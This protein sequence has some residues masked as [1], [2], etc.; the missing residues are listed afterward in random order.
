ML[1]RK[2]R[3][4]S[5]SG[6]TEKLL[7]EIADKG[8]FT[9][10]Y[11]SRVPVNKYVEL[12]GT[13]QTVRSFLNEI[14]SNEYVKY[15]VKSD[16]IILMPSDYLNEQSN[17][18]VVGKI[19]DEKTNE[20][21]QFANVFLINKSTGTI[22]NVDG[23][24]DLNLRSYDKSDTVCVSFLGYQSRKIPLSLLDSTFVTI[25]LSQE[26]QKIKEV[27][28]K[29][30]DALEIIKVAIRCIPGNYD[31]KPSIMTAFFR[32]SSRQDDQYIALSE[33]VLSV[34]KESYVSLR[35]DQIKILKGRKGSNVSSQEYINYIVQGGL[36]NNFKLDIVKHG[37]SFLD[38]D[39]FSY[40]DY[41]LE[42][43]SRYRGV[44]VYVIRFDQ[45][46]L[47]FPLYRGRI[48][49][50]KETY[51][52]VKAEFS[53][54]PKGIGY[55]RDMYVVKSPVNIKTKPLYANYNVNYRKIHD[56]WNL[57]YVRSEVSLFVKGNR[58]KKKKNKISSTF[59]SIS[60]FVVTDKDTI[61][62]CRF[63]NN[64]ISRSNDVLVKQISETDENFWGKENIIL[65][66]EPLLETIVK[67]NRHRG[68]EII[69]ELP[70]ARTEE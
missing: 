40:Y 46:D 38:E 68:K 11:S 55:A 47:H 20:P 37:V 56:R 63:K 28:I 3:I 53:L 18:R 27:W 61:D 51:A 59:T 31:N 13:R 8:G 6:Y 49:I 17:Q 52:I 22:S 58:K 42:K 65:P 66:D 41:K 9:F 15:Y 48:Y 19:V 34:Y 14:F 45:K 30:V 16:K 2:V 60:E 24:F 39:N 57:D 67:L 35:N 25:K 12:S 4:V 64:E 1:E 69:P 43:I 54:S 44:P 26:D 33:A 10:T 50:D 23:K 70:V 7:N 36:Y 5:R 32:E 21:V 29:P 62:V